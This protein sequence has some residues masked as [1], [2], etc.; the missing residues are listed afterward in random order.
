MI[1]SNTCTACGKVFP[2]AESI[3][4]KTPRCNECVRKNVMAPEPKIKAKKAVTKED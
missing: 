2:V 1:V 4:F 3:A